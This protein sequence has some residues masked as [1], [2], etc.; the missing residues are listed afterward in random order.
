MLILN[1]AYF[2]PVEYFIQILHHKQVLIED[3]EHFVKQ[4]LRNRCR[5]VT[6][7]GPLI[8]TAGLEHCRRNHLPLKEV[9]ISYSNNWHIINWKT[10]ESAYASSPFFLY[11]RDFFEVFFRKKHIWLLDLNA[12]ILAC[13]LKVL[14]IQADISFTG[15]FYKTYAEATDLRYAIHHSETMMNELKPYLQVFGE[16]HGFIAN[17]SILDLIFNRGPYS[18]TYLMDACALMKGK[19]A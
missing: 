5:I 10:L 13:C 16:R 11:Y 9:K 8:L 17:L 12:E 1:T 3:S 19:T 15:I 2:P 6:A 18:G 7:N 14:E 4:S